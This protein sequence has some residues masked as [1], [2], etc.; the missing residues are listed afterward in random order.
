MAT[1]DGSN[2]FNYNDRGRMLGVTNSS[3]TT[4]YLYSAL[5]QLIEKASATPSTTVS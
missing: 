4:G 5:G 3:G 2:T 1:S